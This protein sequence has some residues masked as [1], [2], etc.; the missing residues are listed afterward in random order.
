[1]KY[2]KGEIREIGETISPVSLISPKKQF[3]GQKKE[4][5]HGFRKAR[6]ATLS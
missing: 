1:M 6:K 3:T 4:K 2:K 5:N